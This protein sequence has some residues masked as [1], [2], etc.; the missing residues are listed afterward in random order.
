LRGDDAGRLVHLSSRVPTGGLAGVSLGAVGAKQCT[1][2][3]VSCGGGGQRGCVINCSTG[4]RP[5]RLPVEA[6]GSHAECA[7]AHRERE[8]G[9]GVGVADRH[10]HDRPPVRGSCVDGRFENGTPASH[11]FPGRTF[12]EIDLE[13]VEACRGGVACTDGLDAKGVGQSRDSGT[14]DRQSVQK[15]CA[16]LVVGCDCVERC[17]CR[18]ELLATHVLGLV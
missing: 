4:E 3:H 2:K 5:G 6:D 14:S 18:D 9:P 17:H 1:A 11:R 7:D 13:F 12:S 8:H 15:R 16:E 10:Q